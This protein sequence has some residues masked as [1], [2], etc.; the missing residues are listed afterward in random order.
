MAWTSFRFW[1]TSGLKLPDFGLLLRGDRGRRFVL[2]WGVLEVSGFRSMKRVGRRFLAQD[3]ACSG[4]GGS[5]FVLLWLSSEGLHAQQ[6]G[7][8]GFA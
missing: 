4:I 1:A 8:L 3:V 5:E 6:R 2:F 7:L